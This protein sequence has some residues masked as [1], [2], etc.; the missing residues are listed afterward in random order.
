[1]LD[2]ETPRR[3]KLGRR[4]ELIS[5]CVDISSYQP[6]SNIKVKN[7]IVHTPHDMGEFTDKNVISR[8]K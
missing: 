6:R 2:I 8:G 1:M 4:A 3:D 7:D 5:T